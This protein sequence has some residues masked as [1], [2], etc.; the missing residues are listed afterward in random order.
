[1]NN[2]SLKIKTLKK[3]LGTGSK[4]DVSVDQLMAL[5]CQVALALLIIF[6]MANVLF[7]MKTKEENLEIKAQLAYY[8]EKLHEI[9]STE[10][11]M[12]YTLREQALIN[13][14]RQKLFNAL[15]IIEN[16]DRVSLALTFFSSVKD[17]GSKVFAVDTVLSGENIT[18]Q[19]FIEGCK[20]ANNTLPYRKEMRMEWVSRVL[21][22]TGMHLSKSKKHLIT[23]NFETVTEENRQWLIKEIRKRTENLYIDSCDLQRAVLANLQK[24]YQQNLN[25]LKGTQVYGL[26]K[27]Y[28]SASPE[29]K[30]VLIQ[31][32]RE[33]LY[34]HAKSVLQSQNILLLRDV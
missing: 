6:V 1:M 15:D 18:D 10:P 20:F 28:S 33:D 13:L 32:I 31:R 27:Q 11:G 22:L 2:S 34:Q 16:Q 3:L 12:Q 30:N 8:Q 14:Q 23:Q 26:I 4:E 7:N 19:H 25:S 17:D 29:E 21:F 24:Y 9:M 5:L